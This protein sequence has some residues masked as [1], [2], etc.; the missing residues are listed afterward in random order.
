LKIDVDCISCFVHQSE[1]IIKKFVKNREERLKIIKSVLKSL[2]DN[3]LPDLKPIELYPYCYNTLYK[4]L[5]ISDFYKEEKKRSNE[6]IINISDN[7]INKIRAYNPLKNSIKLSIAGNIV[8]YGIKDT[9]NIMNNEITKILESYLET[10]FYID[11][12]EEFITLLPKTKSLLFLTDNSGEIVFDKIFLTILKEK[13]PQIE[14]YIAGRDENV[15]NDITYNELVE[16]GFNKI[17]KVVKNGIKIPGAVEYLFSDDFLNIWN[18]VDIIIAKGQG[19][20][21]GLSDAKK[22]N[23]FFALLAKCKLIA[24]HLG[25]PKMSMIFKSNNI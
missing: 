22:N 8:D 11:D 3:Y 14:I 5:N 2:N 1:S 19:N 10:E 20:F 9:H 12:F 16:L 13:Y 18:N 25:V 24:D 7:F 23:I 17:G 21:E 4:E 6:I 15:L